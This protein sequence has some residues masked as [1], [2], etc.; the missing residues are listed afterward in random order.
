MADRD[1][2][3]EVMGSISTCK[4]AIFVCKHDNST[5]ISRIGPKRTPWMYLRSGL[6][7]FEDGWP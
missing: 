7:K 5:N 4:F 3:V 1:L 2:S 6:V